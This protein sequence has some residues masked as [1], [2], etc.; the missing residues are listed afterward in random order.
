MYVSLASDG[1]ASGA[2]LRNSNG[3]DVVYEESGE[4]VTFKA[5]GG[6]ID[7]FV[8]NGPSPAQVPYGMVF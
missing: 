4:Q 3:M 2:F 8:F 5:I 1:S 7:L 6:V